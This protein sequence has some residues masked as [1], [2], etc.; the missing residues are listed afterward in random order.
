MAAFKGGFHRFVLAMIY[1]IIF[2][3]SGII[4]GIYSYVSSPSARLSTA[5]QWLTLKLHSSSQ[6]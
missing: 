5:V 1:A 2:L 3:C 6:S 4:L